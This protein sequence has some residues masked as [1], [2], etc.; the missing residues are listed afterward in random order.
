MENLHTFEDFLSERF[1]F[2]GKQS[3]N[4]KY[5]NEK[6]IS[7]F[8]DVMEVKN[9]K[10]DPKTLKVTVNGNVK[11]Q[12]KKLEY[13]PVNFDSVSGSFEVNGNE[14]ISLDGC[15]DTVGG[16]FNCSGNKIKS[17]QNSPKSVKGEYNCSHNEL[18]SL[19]GIG[20]I[21][22][23][24]NCEYNR[25]AT[26]KGGPIKIEK[27]DF[28]CSYNQ[29]INLEG[30]PFEVN[31]NFECKGNRINNIETTS[32]K[33]VSGFFDISKNAKDFTTD[34]IKAIIEVKGRTVI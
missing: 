25:I 28:I 20:E 6:E 4:T 27:G 24:L 21:K 15:P 19:E 16:D 7:D 2:A 29:L 5:T 11:M 12:F 31:G 17:L 9:Y 8:L 32:L 33:K 10:I 18:N 3:S 26:L 34:E 23:G 14:L 22:K 13:F 30:A 1:L